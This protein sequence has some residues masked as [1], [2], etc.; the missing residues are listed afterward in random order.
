MNRVEIKSLTAGTFDMESHI[1]LLTDAVDSGASI[2]FIAPLS[3]EQAIDYWRSVQQAL[4]N[5]H[6]LLGAYAQGALVGSVQL[7]CSY[8]ANGSHRAEV[9]KLLVSRSHRGQ[10]IAGLLMQA[11]EKQAEELGRWL[12]I[13]DTKQG[14]TA[15]RLYEKLGYTRVGTI[16][17][18]A[19]NSGGGYGGT[20]FFYKQLMANCEP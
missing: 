6:I 1:E 19:A 5:E 12:L 13:L 3:R 10:G 17:N 2:G 18:Y 15:D 4:L 8:K 9:E 20:V 16:P 14:D 7:S 11:I